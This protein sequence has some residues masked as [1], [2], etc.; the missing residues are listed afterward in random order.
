MTKEIN[1]A[2]VG[3][4]RLGRFHAQKYAAMPNVR[5]AMIV[6]VNA[7]AAK[8]VAEEV[9]AEAWSTDVADAA[10]L[11]AASVA[12]PTV[13]HE[14][15]SCQLLAAGTDVLV[16]KP[17]A[18]DSDAA[19]RMVDV[20]KENDRILMV[21]HIERFNPVITHS[22]LGDRPVQYIE[23]VRVAPFSA[24][25]A[26]VSVILDLMIHDID[27]ILE[28]IG[29]EVVSVDS[30]GANVLTPHYDLANARLRF[31]NGAAATITASRVSMKAERVLR[32]FDEGFYC[33]VDMQ[34]R[35]GHRAWIEDG[36]IKQEQ[37]EET[38][39]DPLYNEIEHFLDCVRTRN[40]PLIPGEMGLRSM[41]VAEEIHKALGDKL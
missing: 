9:G 14:E 17:I 38:D 8:A 5:L 1:A 12:T 35:K 25:S 22:G 11:D 23:S 21:G 37:F 16:E 39:G 36:A 34:T 20:A 26:D 15:V 19:Q 3:T 7:D 18:V 24:R 29:D 28:L 33:S 32:C 31:A 10:G 27:L 2:V 6:D 4:G 41:K 30:V 40:T 13:T